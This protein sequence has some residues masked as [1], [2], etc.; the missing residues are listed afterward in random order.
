MGVVHARLK[1]TAEKN[2]HDRNLAYYAMIQPV[3]LQALVRLIAYQ[4]EVTGKTAVVWD[5]PVSV[6]DV[7]IDNRRRGH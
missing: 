7:E 5:M 2:I 1:K 6:G 4:R 3:V